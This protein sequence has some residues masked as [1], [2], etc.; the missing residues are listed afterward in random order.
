M[1][2]ARKLG[3]IV[4]PQRLIHWMTD[5]QQ[6]NE[7]HVITTP[8]AQPHWLQV[9][10][11]RNVLPQPAMQWDAIPRVDCTKWGEGVPTEPNMPLSQ[12]RCPRGTV[13]GCTTS[14]RPRMAGCS[15]T[16]IADRRPGLGA[17][18]EREVA[19]LRKGRHEERKRSFTKHFRRAISAK[20]SQRARLT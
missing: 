12:T 14:L 20:G 17:A 4:Y 18:S 3:G 16:S 5:A 2:I 19:L 15:V 11:S 9:A 1:S 8:S 6:Q 10:T 7:I 13:R